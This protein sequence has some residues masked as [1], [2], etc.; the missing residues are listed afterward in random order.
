[1][2]CLLWLGF[3]K[4]YG[5]LRN[6]I[7]AW[8]SF[9]WCFLGGCYSFNEKNLVQSVMG[10]NI[11]GKSLITKN[12]Q[13]KLQL[14]VLLISHFE[15]FYNDYSRSWERGRERGEREREQLLWLMLEDVMGWFGRGPFC[16]EMRRMFACLQWQPAW[17]TFYSISNNNNRQKSILNH[18]LVSRSDCQLILDQMNRVNYA[19]HSAVSVIPSMWRIWYW[20]GFF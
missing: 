9:V 3:I 4:V 10:R 6:M 11:K 7:D 12:S 20:A 8:F 15:I 13:P 17:L 2:L 14:H 19:R 1:M 16:Q 18:R 5:D